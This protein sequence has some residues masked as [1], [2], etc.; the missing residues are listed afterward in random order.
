MQLL[1]SFSVNEEE[2]EHLQ[3]KITCEIN[4]FREKRLE[5]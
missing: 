1:S 2:L 3:K 4:E 5:D